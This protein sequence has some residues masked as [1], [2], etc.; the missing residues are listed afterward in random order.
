MFRRTVLGSGDRCRPSMDRPGHNPPRDAGAA[1]YQPADHRDAGT[2]GHKPPPTATP[3]AANST[4]GLLLRF[5]G[6]FFNGSQ[7]IPD[8]AWPYNSGPPSELRKFPA[9][10]NSPP[11]PY[12]EYQLGGTPIIGDR[13]EQTVYPLMKALFDGPDGQWW[14]D[15]RIFLTGWVEI[16]GN[17]STSSNQPGNNGNNLYGNAP[18]LYDQVPNALNLH[19]LDFHAIRLPDTYQT[20]HIDWG[21]RRRCPVW[22]GLS[23]YD[24]EGT[25]QQPVASSTTRSMATTCRWSAA[26]STSHGSPRA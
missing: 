4:D 21:F 5:L 2:A 24:H 7:D 1:G 19:Q 3:V 20:D 8:S 17:A 23:L 12:A 15:S 13:N 26:T 10:Q 6:N 16:G 22:S 18:Y 9:P 14:K 25:V 11:F